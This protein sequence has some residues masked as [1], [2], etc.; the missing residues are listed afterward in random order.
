MWA[1]C[2]LCINDSA[3]SFS[4][5][6]YKTIFIYF[7]VVLFSFILHIIILTFYANYFQPSHDGKS[8]T[9]VYHDKEELNGMMVWGTTMR[10]LTVFDSVAFSAKFDD[11][12]LFF[13]Y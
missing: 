10:I 9:I 11:I 8:L 3:K 13:E 5:S 4:F 1:C 7:L 12:A 6:L 2:K